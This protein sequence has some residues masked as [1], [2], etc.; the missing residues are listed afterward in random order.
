MTLPRP[1]RVIFPVA[2]KPV[3]LRSLVPLLG[4]LVLFA[5]VCIAVEW[6]GL[7]RFSYRPAFWFL[8]ATPWIWWLHHAGSSG[9]SK[10]RAL[11]ALLIRLALVGAF[12]TLLAEPRA[13]RRS[14]VLSVVYALD[15]SD[16]MGEKVSDQALSWV[17]QTVAQK[18]AKDEAGLVVFGREA[19][20]ELPPRTTFPFEAVN[21]RVGRDG[22]DL[23]K[24][25]GLAAAMLPEQN[26]G[27]IV[28]VSDGN[29]TEGNVTA[30]LDELKARGIAVDVLPVGF[31]YEKEVW[32]ERLDLPRV[33][34]AGETYEAS[35]LLNSLQK[36]AG[37]LILQENGK[38]IFEKQVEFE[39]GKTRFAMP[40]YMREPGFYEYAASIEMAKGED[41]WTENNLA[42]GDLFLRGEG[43]VL[44]VTDPRA[45]ARDW[46]QLVEA[47][48]NSERSVQVRMAYEFPRDALSLQPY[49]L[50][51]FPN[52]P[53]DSFDPVQLQALRD[54]VYNNGTGF[55]MLGG[56]QSYGPGGFHRTPVEEALPVT[57]DVHQKKVLPKGALAIILHTC[58]FAEGNTWAKRMAKEA[59]RVLGA[60]DEVGLIAFTWG[61]GSG[62]NNGYNWIFELTPAGQYA[63][64]A[65][66]INNAEPGDMPDFNTPM[67]MG[68]KGLQNSD[69]ALK[70]MIVISDGDP[71]PPTPQLIQSFVDAKI[72]VSMIAINPHGGQDASIMQSIS[73]T[74]GGRYY[75]PQDPSQLPS[76]FIKEAK[77]LKRS[78]LQ[79]KVFTPEVQMPSPVLK[80]IDAMPPLRGYVL[81]TI[82]PRASTILRT[83]ATKEEP[84]QLDPLLATWRFGLGVTAAWT[85]DF[86][87]SWAKD[88]LDWGQYRAFI[89][90]LAIEISRVEA[91]TDLRLN[92]FAA[93][94]NGII[95]VEDFAKDEAFLEVEARVTGPRGETVNVPLKQIGSRRYQGQFP[96]WGK[97][98]YQVIAAAAGRPGAVEAERAIG[99]FAV[100]YSPEYLKFRSDP[101]VLKQIAERTGGRVLDGSMLDLFHPA[102]QSRESSLPVIDWFLL[103]IACLVPIDVAVRRVQLDWTVIRGWFT[104]RVA[105]S[106]G[107]TMGALL[108]RK[109]QVT[110]NLRPS[111]TT[112]PSV[113]FKP[114]PSAPRRPIP[115]P[116]AKP[117]V[118]ENPDG[119]QSTTERLLARKRRR[120][121]DQS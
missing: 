64:L 83:P 31:S 66:L 72:S 98:R 34:K 7:L 102:R 27:R 35:V 36:G 76:I 80:G 20:V 105:D 103:V 42:I 40:L 106:S 116:A 77:T 60:Q 75:F 15:V 81:T 49:D 68:L 9:L 52:A 30:Q 96:L 90:Q 65:P 63:K 62:G 51:I 58:E 113:A 87:P 2:R 17:M 4:F 107:E 118:P 67:Q 25:L 79:N 111:E 59:M 47:L 16:S 6:R 8:L 109:K 61:K 89:K 22:S 115:P 120:E 13:V 24:S 44:V 21:S 85:S 11:S 55:L 100:P 88:W 54:A 82:K 110:T 104:R 95:S 86:G 14:D 43:K 1:I 114:A 41:G 101:I 5:A 33:V 26:Q 10:G 50:I 121:E 94:S 74:T 69:A 46:Q 45:D 108:Q 56:P 70:H 84:D 93:D 57:M 53:A 48:K 119:A 28:L 37:K 99:G 117:A 97:G 12:V 29:E 73:Q 18:P 71:S 78:M 112:R 39:P 32:L 91:K 38:V 92:A 19:A 3:T 23:A